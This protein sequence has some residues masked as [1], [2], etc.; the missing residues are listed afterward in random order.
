M[1]LTDEAFAAKQLPDLGHEV[2]DFQVFTWRLSKWR[3][4]E[5]KITGPEFDCGGHR[6]YVPLLV[7]ATRT[8]LLSKP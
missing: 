2:E 5:K 8:G 1:A 7:V 6:W 4:L 3:Q